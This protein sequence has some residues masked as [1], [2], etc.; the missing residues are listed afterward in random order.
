M[1]NGTA[2][3]SAETFDDH[4]DINTKLTSRDVFGILRRSLSYIWPA[5]G[6]F[7]LKFFLMVG[8]FVPALVAIWPAKILIDYVILKEGFD[9]SAVRFPPYIQ[10]FVDAIAG[11][12]PTGMLVAVLAVLVPLLLIFGAGIGESGGSFAFMAQGAD[13]ASQSENMISAGWSMTGGLWGLADLLCNIRLVQRVSNVLRTELFTKLIRLPVRT[14]DDQR[15]GDSIYRT[16]YDAPAIQGVCF[17]ISLM[18]VISLLGGLTA[19]AVMDYS[20]GQTIPELFYLGLA[21]MPL[22]LLVTIPLAGWARRMS[23]ESRAAGTVTTNRIEEEITNIAAVQSHGV[24]ER[25]HS[26]F[27]EASKES[28]RRF[29]KLILVNIGIDSVT[30]IGSLAVMWLWMFL[31]V[32]EKIIVGELTPG[33]FGVTTALFGTISGTSITFGRLWIDLQQNVAGVRRVLFYLDLP[34][35]DDFGGSTAIPATVNSIEFKNVAYRYNDD[36]DVLRDVSFRAER[37]QTVAIVGPTGSG[38]TTLAYLLPRFLAPSEGRISLNGISLEEFDLNQLRRAIAIVFQEHTLF[39]ASI[40]D[41]LTEGNPKALDAQITNALEVCGLQDFVATLPDGLE[42]NL[43]TNAANLSVGQKQRLSIAR[44]LLC[45][46]PVLI[47]DE[48]TAALD[49]TTEQRLIKSLASK[50]QNRILFLIAHRLTT[51]QTAD[52]ILFLDAGRVVESGS[53]AELMARDGRYRRYVESQKIPNQE[54]S[55]H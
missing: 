44:G 49:P 35:D 34:S 33:D 9:A 29:R 42:T 46:S 48:P 14:I 55:S 4:I 10:P 36:Q 21:T 15:I 5:R 7:T 51:I 22:A 18:P 54:R 8:S 41:N 30:I 12:D 20:Y 19:L 3:P 37:G 27:V 24:Q 25:E 13:T 43:G 1:P 32:S 6:L 50:S 26:T 52:L 45:E 53:H 23:Q 39:A 47:L 2:Q 38:K 17:D 11:L 40:R 16:M 31:L 28:F